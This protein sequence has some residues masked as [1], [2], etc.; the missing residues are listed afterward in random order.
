MLHALLHIP[1]DVL[2]CGPVWASWSFLIE[3][4]CGI[5]I[6]S[7]SSRLNP[8]KSISNRVLE[9]SQLSA[10]SLRHQSVQRALKQG[11]GTPGNT[12][13]MEHTYPNCEQFFYWN[14]NLSTAI[15][16]DPFTILQFPC[17]R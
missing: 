6:D 5:T 12:S 8:Y 15:F 16:A 11:L 1:D 17:L 7:L 2:H 3:R 14:G 13:S 10:L 4:Y 9:M